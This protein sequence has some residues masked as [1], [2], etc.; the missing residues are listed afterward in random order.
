MT[1][2]RITRVRN[3]EPVAPK[4]TKSQMLATLQSIAKMQA[5]IASLTANIKP[6]FESLEEDMIAAKMLTLDCDLATASITQSSGK[7]SVTIDPKKFYDKVSEEDFF[8]SITVG[9]AKAK[10]VM[11]QKEIDRI[12]TTVP[13]KAGPKKL[14]IELL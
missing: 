11:G 10:V 5:T 8:A 12:S 9:M 6:L 1:I 2:R 7:S 3:V 4:K 13:G 14:S